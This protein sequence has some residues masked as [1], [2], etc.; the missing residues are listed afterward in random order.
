MAVF[1]GA[2]R[3]RRIA[4]DWEGGGG[5]PYATRLADAMPGLAGP[6]RTRVYAAWWG[7]RRGAV[8]EGVAEGVAVGPSRGVSRMLKRRTSGRERTETLL[9][10]TQAEKRGRLTAVDST[11]IPLQGRQ[12]NIDADREGKEG[13]GL[14]PEPRP[15]VALGVYYSQYV[16]VVSLS[17]VSCFSLEFFLPMV[18]VW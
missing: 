4:R 5:E 10:P 7:P 3:F 8:A 15:P 2:A 9:G 1:G 11:W 6:S 16:S 13:R 18:L 12:R 17:M 14:A